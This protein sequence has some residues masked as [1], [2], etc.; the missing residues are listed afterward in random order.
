MMNPSQSPSG[1]DRR[2]FLQAGAAAVALPSAAALVAAPSVALASMP[3]L[4]EP[5]PIF[6]LIE[7]HK[8]AER[9]YDEHCVLDDHWCAIIPQEKRMS[10][11]WGNELELVETDDPRW[12]DFNKESICRWQRTEELTYKRLS[13][14]N[15]SLGGAVALLSYAIEHEAEGTAWPDYVSDAEGNLLGSW[16][17]YLHHV[18]LRALE[19]ATGYGHLFAD[20]E[21]DQRAAEGIELRLLG[22]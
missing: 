22:S 16:S 15:L 9:D 19:R 17:S 11:Q 10:T 20:A 7:A 14:P 18:V 2:A 12:I 4:A 8:E 1:L 3:K 5:D 6:A 13:T 21:A